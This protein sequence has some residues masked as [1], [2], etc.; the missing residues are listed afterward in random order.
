MLVAVLVG[1]MIAIVVGGNL[2]TAILDSV[3]S[4]PEDTSPALSGLVNILPLVFVIVIIVIIVGAVAYISNSVDFSWPSFGRHKEI[5]VSVTGNSKKFIISIKRASEKLE[6]YINNLDTI[7]GITTQETT[8]TQKA[9][10]EL[11]N[12]K[13]FMSP[14]TEKNGVYDWYL[15]DKLVD[16][17]IFKVVGLHK[18][19][20]SLNKVYLLGKEQDK[21][22]LEEASNTC[23]T[24]Q[25][26]AI[27][28]QSQLVT[29]AIMGIVTTAVASNMIDA[30]RKDTVNNY[31]GYR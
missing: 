9:A 15:T 13:L 12:Q 2:V 10:L 14:P 24:T 26:S 4:L 29:A 23:V 3:N 22:F 31:K 5:E 27:P 11:K 6:P 18:N 28:R 20:A 8:S 21:T 19:D 17:D 25:I 1:L 7:L 16:Q 30:I